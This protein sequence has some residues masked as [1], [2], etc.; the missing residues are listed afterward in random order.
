MQ[1]GLIG[2]GRRSTSMVRRLLKSGHERGFIGFAVGHTRVS[3]AVSGYHAR[4]LT[5]AE[6]A[7]QIARRLRKWVDVFEAGRLSHPAGSA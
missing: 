5:C 7:A 2:L 3:D 6:A 4:T 1:L